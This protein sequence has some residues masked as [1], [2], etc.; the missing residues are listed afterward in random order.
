MKY[1][2]NGSLIKIEII[3]K[4]NIIKWNIIKMETIKMKKL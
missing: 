4:K 2:K 1:Y 3:I